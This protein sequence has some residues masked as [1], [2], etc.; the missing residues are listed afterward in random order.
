[1]IRHAVSDGV[2]TI[3]IDRPKRRNALNHDAVEAL[4]GALGA[5]TEAGAR[6][7]IVTGADGHFCAGADLTELEDLTFTHRLREMLDHLAGLEIPTIAAIS[8]ACM[9]LGMQLALGCDIRIATPDAS[10]GVPVAKLGLMVDH[11]TLRRLALAAG[12]GTARHMVLFAE[13]LDAAAAHRVGLVQDLGDLA[14]AEVLAQRVTSLAPL[15]ISG[16]KLGLNLAGSDEEPATYRG[17]RGGLGERGPGRGTDRV[18][19]AAATEVHRAL[20][21]GGPPSLRCRPC[22]RSVGLSRRWPPR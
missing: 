3:T 12:W 1:M 2:A 17:V 10:F 9:G 18:R 11:W 8:G 5:S 19:R 13:V 4:D 7:V 20:M 16:S 22:M 14:A 21:A 6:C 15:S